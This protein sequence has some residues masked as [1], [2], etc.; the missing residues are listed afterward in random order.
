MRQT[1]RRNCYKC[2]SVCF[3]LL[4]LHIIS[5]EDESI[6]TQKLKLVISDISFNIS[7]DVIGQRSYSHHSRF[8]ITAM[9]KS[10]EYTIPVHHIKL[11]IL[12][13]AF[14]IAVHGDHENG[15]LLSIADLMIQV[16]A[17]LGTCQFC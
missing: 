13:L 6:G 2:F 3:I 12:V 17:L 16:E 15:G 7:T 8:T 10:I 11:R 4:L 5:R 14:L 9:L 1:L